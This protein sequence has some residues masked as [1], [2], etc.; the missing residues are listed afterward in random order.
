MCTKNTGV[1]TCLPTEYMQKYAHAYCVYSIAEG[2]G[3]AYGP[4]PLA[5]WAPFEVGCSPS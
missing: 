2:L 3:P 5:P 1:C 4:G